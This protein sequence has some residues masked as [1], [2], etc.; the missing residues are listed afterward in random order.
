VHLVVKITQLYHNARY[1]KHV[2]YLA[3]WWFQETETCRQI[4]NIDY[5]YIYIYTHTHKYMLCYW[6][7]ELLY[8][9]LHVSNILCSSTRLDLLDRVRPSTWQTACVNAWKTHNIRLHVRYS[10]PD[11]EYEIFET[12][13]R[14]EELN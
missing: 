1:K 10:L 2:L 4:F 7:N 8:C 11:D 9:L 12:C 5:Q 3:W 14:Q 6:L 13:R